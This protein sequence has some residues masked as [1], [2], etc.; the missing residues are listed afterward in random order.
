MGIPI[1]LTFILPMLLDLQNLAF[2]FGYRDCSIFGGTL[3]LWMRL[4]PPLI[5]L[6]IYLLQLIFK[7]SSREFWTCFNWSVTIGGIFWIVSQP[8]L[9]YLI[10][11]LPVGLAR[12]KAN[13][14]LLWSIVG[15]VV[16]GFFWLFGIGEGELFILPGGSACWGT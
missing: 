6:I 16:S 9:R 10:Y 8:Y 15:I 4:V 14:V 11:P 1:F 7:P 5:V 3:T 2:F 13:K 12:Q